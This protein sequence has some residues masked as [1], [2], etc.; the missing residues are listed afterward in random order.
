MQGTNLQGTR[1]MIFRG[2]KM[3]GPRHLQIRAIDENHSLKVA[4]QAKECLLTGWQNAEPSCLSQQNEAVTQRLVQSSEIYAF[5]SMYQ[6]SESSEVFPIYT[7]WASTAVEWYC[8]LRC[9]AES[10]SNF[11]LSCIFNLHM[12]CGPTSFQT[13]S[14][15]ALLEATPKDVLTPYIVLNS[16]Q[17]DRPLFLKTSLCPP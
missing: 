12:L 13:R 11:S 9:L 14:P 4:A 17:R 10:L 6:W 15:A 16:R 3:C 7:P 5:L 1:D 2:S 8:S